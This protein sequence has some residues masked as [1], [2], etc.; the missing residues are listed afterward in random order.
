[1]TK[2]VDIDFTKLANAGHVAHKRPSGDVIFSQGETGSCMYILRAGAVEIRRGDKVV[3]TVGP[4]G[5]FGEM[6][7]IDGSP[8]SAEARAAADCEL[9]EIDEKTFVYLVHE[10]PYFALDVM[11]IMAAR[12]RSMNELI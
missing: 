3:E 5:I 8:R 11:R 6:S 2:V 7:L 4:G 12:I 1:M 10:A 9:L